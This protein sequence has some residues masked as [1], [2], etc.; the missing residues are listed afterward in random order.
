VVVVVALASAGTTATHPVQAQSPNYSSVAEGDEIV[1][2][3]VNVKL[4]QGA[5][6]HSVLAGHSL[7]SYEPLFSGTPDADLSRWLRVFVAD[8][9]EMEEVVELAA[10]PNVEWAEPSVL[11]TDVLSLAPNDPCYQPPNPGCPTSQW[12][13]SRGFVAPR[14]FASRPSHTA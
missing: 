5:A 14:P 10:D 12:S 1:P 8:G 6:A 13:L 9:Q 4:T 2:G 3:R 7:S 11:R